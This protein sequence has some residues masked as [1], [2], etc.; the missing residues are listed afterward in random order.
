MGLGRANEDYLVEGIPIEFL[1][2]KAVILINARDNIFKTDTFFINPTQMQQP[3]IDTSDIE[4]IHFADNSANNNPIPTLDI[5]ASDYQ[6][7]ILPD[8]PVSDTDIPKF[9]EKAELGRALFFTKIDGSA[10]SDCHSPKHGFTAGQQ[11]SCGRGC[12][13]I[14]PNRRPISGKKA[15]TPPIKSP[16]VIGIS[17]SNMLLWTGFAGSNKDPLEGLFHASISSAVLAIDGNAHNMGISADSIRVHHPSIFKQF[18]DVYVGVSEDNLCDP[19]NIAE[20]LGAFQMRLIPNNSQFQKW[21]N[22]EVAMSKKAER[23]LEIFDNKCA[24][25]HKPP[26][27]GDDEFVDVGFP[28]LINEFHDGASKVNEGRYLVTR[29]EEDKGKFRIMR[30]ATNVT[31]QIRWGHGGTFKTLE[32]CIAGH[33]NID[34]LSAAEIDDIIEFLHTTTDRDLLNLV[35]REGIR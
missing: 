24:N 16:S 14:S 6:A 26:F 8:K 34:S 13:G 9:E 33:K 15:D 5:S 32:D 25:C 28:N 22:G 21:L 7:Y 17:G 1:D 35:P 23:G 12:E 27:L 10:C 2:K 4:V 31:Q 19:V 29:K 3:E 18:K 30:L 20:C 11:Q